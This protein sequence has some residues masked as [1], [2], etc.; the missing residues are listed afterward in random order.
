MQIKNNI[1]SILAKIIIMK[2]LPIEAK[3]PE[4]R[5]MRTE[6][7]MLATGFASPAQSFV[8]ER[9]NIHDLLVTNETAS[10]FFELESSTYQHALFRQGDILVVDRSLPPTNSCYIVAILHN[11]FTVI[12]LQ[13]KTNQWKAVSCKTRQIIHEEFEFWG[14]ITAIVHKLP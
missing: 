2:L 6:R 5:K 1:F 8:K 11:E 4:S 9:L 14:T 7:Q 3:R 13:G 10:F 12:Y